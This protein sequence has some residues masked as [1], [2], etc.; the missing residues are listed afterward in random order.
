MTDMRDNGPSARARAPA[1]GLGFARALTRAAPL[2]RRLPHGAGRVSFTQ[3]RTHTAGHQ[4]PLDS[5]DQTAAAQRVP[6]LVVGVR[7][8]GLGSLPVIQARRRMPYQ[9]PVSS[10]ADIAS[11]WCSADAI[12]RRGR[13]NVCCSGRRPHTASGA[14]LRRRPRSSSI[15]QRQRGGVAP[16][17]DRRARFSSSPCAGLSASSQPGSLIRSTG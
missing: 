17:N 11:R 1:Q 2:R 8:H 6:S 9:R 12:R 16:T 4:L 5:A 10:T 13:S 3:N 15:R 7:T 14:G